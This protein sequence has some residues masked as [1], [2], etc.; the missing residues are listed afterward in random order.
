[1]TVAPAQRAEF[2]VDTAIQL[3]PLSE[4]YY[5]VFKELLRYRDWSEAH[6]EPREMPEERAR[7]MLELPRDPNSGC[8]VWLIERQ[9]DLQPVGVITIMPV[10][11]F[12]CRQLG[13]WVL[14][15]FHGQGVATTAVKAVT[16]L[17]FE[18]LNVVRIQAQV[19]PSNPAS[20]RVMDKAGYTREAELAAAHQIEGVPVMAYLYG[21]VRPDVMEALNAR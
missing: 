5:P 10:F 2:N 12:L 19:V 7:Q 17:A 14:P 6:P 20:V 1:M 3:R 16:K 21:Q 11:H 4:E 8:H 18:H 15:E 13:Y 9:Q